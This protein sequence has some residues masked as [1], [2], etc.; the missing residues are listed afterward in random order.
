MEIKARYT[1]LWAILKVGR[2]ET[3]NEERK[4]KQSARVVGGELERITG[5]ATQKNRSSRVRFVRSSPSPLSALR[6]R[7]FSIARHPRSDL[8]ARA[9]R[10]ARKIAKRLANGRIIIQVDR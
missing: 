6:N 5:A 3:G 10:I 7:A 1:T 8:V 9:T 4:E 2:R